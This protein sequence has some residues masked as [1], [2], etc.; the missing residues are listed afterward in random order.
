M[1]SALLDTCVLVPS[2]PRDS[3]S[4]S[5][6]RA[7]IGRCGAQK[8]DHGCSARPS[9]PDVP[10]GG[11]ASMKGQVVTPM[12]TYGLRFDVNCSILFT[13]LPLGQRAA[14]A[15]AAGFG[16]VEFWWPW[17]GMVPSDAEADAFVAS[18]ADA[19]VDLVSL[20]FHTGDMAAGERGIVSHPGRA[21]QFRENVAAAVEI[22]GRTGCT[23]LNAPYGLRLPGVGDAEQ[24]AV[25]VENLAFA[26]AAAREAGAAVLVEAINS[27][28]IPGFP[29][30]SSD[31]A[32]AVIMK[33]GSANV[34]FLADLYHLAKMGED[35]A[36]VLGRYRESI[37]HVQVADS[38]GRGAPGTG[39]VDFEPLFARLAA[40][41]YDGWVGL[42]Y[43][44]PAGGD[45]T[46]GFGWLR[47]EASR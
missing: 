23:R 33:A 29:V 12:R 10:S 31:K 11:A 36:D 28:D 6:A 13:E 25:A 46:A 47:E 45:S 34:G 37:L 22:A 35:V 19:G 38:P 3:C 40:Q 24:D 42:E 30:D 41:G 5:P 4:R 17:E 9:A 14:A 7:P 15:K 39:T 8:C 16:G 1:F 21:A 2:R 27:V 26:A 20:N 18:I 32:M 44:P 43:V